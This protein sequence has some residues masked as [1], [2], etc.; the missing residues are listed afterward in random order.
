MVNLILPLLLVLLG[1]AGGFFLRRWELA[2][3]FEPSGLAI[4]WSPPSLILIALSVVLAAAFALFC[5]KTRHAPADYNEAFSA[6]NNWLYLIVMAL[7]AATMLFAGI[8]G[9]RYNGYCGILCKL[10]NFMCLLSFFC[11]LAAAWSNFRGKSLRFSPTL[12]APGYTLCLWLVSAYQQ[13]AA[14]PV[15]LDYVYELLA[16][17]CTLIGLYFSAGF[18]FGR[19]KIRRCAVFSL[20]GIYFSMVTLADPHSTADRLLFLFCILYQLASVS[21]LL[22]H[23]FVAYTPTPAP[24]P[25]PSN[26][27]NN[28]QEVTPD[29]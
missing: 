16:I 1:G 24:V 21:A 8:L 13:Q 19:P 10:T 18:S 11:I 17:I 3:V 5:R 23:V 27:T 9:L 4:L 25:D 26:E 14:D 6:Q 29:E 28:T 12:L 22:Y 20:L 15:V 7:A 2:T